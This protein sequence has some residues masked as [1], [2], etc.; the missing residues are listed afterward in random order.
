[1]VELLDWHPTTARD[2]VMLDKNQTMHGTDSQ[3][4]CSRWVWGR[5]HA[6]VKKKRTVAKPLAFLAV[7]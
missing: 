3:A 1:M 6:A 5:G 4:P 7:Q 2:K